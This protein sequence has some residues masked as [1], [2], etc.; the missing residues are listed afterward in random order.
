[1]QG[2]GI[3]DYGYTGIRLQMVETPNAQNDSNILL[4]FI[5]SKIFPNIFLSVSVYLYTALLSMKT[6]NRYIVA[7]FAH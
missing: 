6:D 5:F 3:R 1:M 2:G 7:F 4:L